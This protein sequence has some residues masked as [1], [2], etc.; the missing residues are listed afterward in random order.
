MATSL[1]TV[2]LVPMATLAVLKIQGQPVDP[3]TTPSLMANFPN[4]STTGPHPKV[5]NHYAQPRRWDRQ[6]GLSVLTRRASRKRREE[7]QQVKTPH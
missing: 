1:Q 6:P 4:P 3:P 5:T 7:Q 2:A